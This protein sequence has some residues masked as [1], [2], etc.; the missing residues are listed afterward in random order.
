MPGARKQETAKS[1]R[2]NSSPADRLI[3]F[4][5][6]TSGLRKFVFQDPQRDDSAAED[7][8]ESCGQSKRDLLQKRRNA[9]RFEWS[10]VH[11]DVERAI[12][13]DRPGRGRERLKKGKGP[14][15]GSAPGPCLVPLTGIEPVRCCHRGILSPLRLPIPPQRQNGTSLSYY[16]DPAKSR[17]ST[18]LGRRRLRS[19]D[20]SLT[21]FPVERRPVLP[22]SGLD[23]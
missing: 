23:L 20:R 10:A 5:A 11:S 16:T 15:R 9:K 8:C 13:L 17:N 1:R 4:P 7:A 22:N 21:S 18:A 2:A 3:F 14:E 6:R 12:S 19:E